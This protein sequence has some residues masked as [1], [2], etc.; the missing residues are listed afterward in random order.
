MK[1]KADPRARSHKL[2][3][4]YHNLLLGAVQWEHPAL[5]YWRSLLYDLLALEPAHVA[6]EAAHLCGTQPPRG[7]GPFALPHA[8]LVPDQAQGGLQPRPA[9]AKGQRCS[10]W[11]AL[12]AVFCTQVSPPKQ[13]TWIS[14]GDDPTPG[15]YDSIARLTGAA[16][17]AGNAAPVAPTAAASPSLIRPP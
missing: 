9:S 4:Y 13:N 15:T 3:H 16:V 17:G 2:P 6:G 10:G 11:P 14:A 8:P 7:F 12:P 5:T 1:P